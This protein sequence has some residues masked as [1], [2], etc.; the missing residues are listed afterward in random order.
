MADETPFVTEMTDWTEISVQGVSDGLLQSHTSAAPS[1]LVRY[2]RGRTELLF[3]DFRRKWCMRKFSATP[4][5]KRPS[6][7]RCGS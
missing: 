4:M 5:L 3:I 1:L 6:G 7:L 2:I